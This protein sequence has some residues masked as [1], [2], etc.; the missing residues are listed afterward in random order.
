[1]RISVSGLASD[2]LASANY[3]QKQSFNLLFFSEI[4]KQTRGKLMEKPATAQ[5]AEALSFHIEPDSVWFRVLSSATLAA[6]VMPLPL[7]C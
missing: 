4:S 7:L 2:F 1:M 5:N 6:V 3:K